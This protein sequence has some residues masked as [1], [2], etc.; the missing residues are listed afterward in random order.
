MP[1]LI[2]KIIIILFTF[3]YEK[4]KIFTSPSTGDGQASLTISP[5]ENQRFKVANL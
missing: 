5:E 4:E 2:D 3:F 1:N